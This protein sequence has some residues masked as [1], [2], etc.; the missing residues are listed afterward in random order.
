MLP[1]PPTSPS[2]RPGAQNQLPNTTPVAPL[3]EPMGNGEGPVEAARPQGLQGQN[4]ASGVGSP[5][6]TPQGR[7]RA[8]AHGEP[9]KPSPKLVGQIRR[10]MEE[11]SD[12]PY[13]PPCRRL[14]GTPPSPTG[15][16]TS[17]GDLGAAP[18]LASPF[19][20]QPRQGRPA[21]SVPPTPHFGSPL[22]PETM[23]VSAG[24][25][26]RPSPWQDERPAARRRLGS[27]SPEP[28]Q[29]DLDA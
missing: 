1:L 23:H 4:D 6:R 24:A 5:P 14:F 29:M 26:K 22:G 21:I 27:V 20:L 9:P 2:L 16:S 11:L 8:L 10:R 28:N 7:Q 13:A 25:P 19:Q 3:R 15:P 17:P 12:Q 18:G